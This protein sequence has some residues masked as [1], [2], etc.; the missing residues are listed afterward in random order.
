MD[1]FCN[2]IDPRLYYAEITPNLRRSQKEARL[3]FGTTPTGRRENYRV[4]LYQ[5]EK[6]ETAVER[7]ETSRS[8]EAFLH[9]MKHFAIR[10]KES[11]KIIPLRVNIKSLRFILLKLRLFGHSWL[12]E[13][14][15][16]A[17]QLGLIERPAGRSVIVQKMPNRTRKKQRLTRLQRREKRQRR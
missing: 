5:N 13:Y 1:E 4:K 17:I 11:G 6:G 7:V 10:D 14:M 12:T 16:Y 15:K 3:R 2:E 8:V 9:F